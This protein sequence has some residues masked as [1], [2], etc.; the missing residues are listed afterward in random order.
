MG[1]HPSISVRGRDVRRLGYAHRLDPTESG[2]A[3]DGDPGNQATD[4]CK[5]RQVCETFTFGLL[6]SLTEQG[7]NITLL[8]SINPPD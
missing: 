4:G 8:P 1:R 3:S 6:P 2:C 7:V 5:Q